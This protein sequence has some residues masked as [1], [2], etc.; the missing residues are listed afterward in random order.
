MVQMTALAKAS[1]YLPSEYAVKSRCAEAAE[2]I[3]RFIKKEMW[4]DKEKK[5]WRSYREGR[6]TIGQTDDY[7][8]L[9]Q[10][11]LAHISAPTWNA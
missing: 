9:I 10:G 4:D 11:E 5:L 2:G 8:F 6:G 3:V 1:T 7:A